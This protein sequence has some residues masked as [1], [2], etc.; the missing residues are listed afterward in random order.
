MPPPPSCLPW[1]VALD[2]RLRRLR[3]EGA[4]CDE[5]AR[6][7]G[8][9]LDDVAARANAL[10]AAAPPVDG[11]PCADDPAR[12]PLPAGHPRTWRPLVAGTLL[13]GGEYPLPFFFR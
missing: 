1:T 12:E 9:T 7:L 13:E 2:T 5:I 8:R 3:A 4:G 6:A 10:G 11:T